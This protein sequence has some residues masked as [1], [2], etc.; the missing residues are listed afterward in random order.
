MIILLVAT[1]LSAN[2]HAADGIIVTAPKPQTKA[3]VRHAAARFVRMA[4]AFDTSGQ[5]ARRGTYC[6]RVIGLP[7]PRMVKLVM[8]RIMEAGDA[9]GLPR[10][11]AGCQ[12][13]LGIVFTGDGDALMRRFEKLRPSLFR[14]L[15]SA[16]NAE[17]FDSGRP[18]RWWYNNDP[19]PA[20]GGPKPETTAIGNSGGSIDVPTLNVWSSSLFETNISV[21]I[22]GT[23]VVVDVNKA[24]GYPL[25]SVASYAAMVSLAQINAVR[26]F[27]GADSILAITTATD[28][29]TS[30]QSLSAWDRA[31]LKTLY[32]LPPNREAWM[33]RGVLQ[34]A[35]V[36]ATENVV[37]DDAERRDP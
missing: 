34:T 12:G 6:P 25:D 19:S 16:K 17:L 20:D 11:R 13:D 7:D 28:R 4:A 31:Y 18:I 37:D 27:S 32:R 5:Y 33:Q 22:G 10:P 30:R 1:A 29:A 36:N 15:N 24:A 2:V 21:W 3:E 8:D 14:R 35:L 9:A 26:D 23:I